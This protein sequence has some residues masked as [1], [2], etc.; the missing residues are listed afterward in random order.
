M[1]ISKSRVGSWIPLVPVLILIWVLAY[2]SVHYIYSNGLNSPPIRSDGFGYYAYLTSIFIDHN[3]QFSSA[4]SHLPFGKP[5]DYGLA[6][7]PGTSRM[8]DRY[9]SGVALLELPFF[10]VAHLYAEK[11]GAVANGYSGIYQFAI[12]VSA[13]FYLTVGAAILYDLLRRR[14]SIPAALITVVLVVFA[15]NV[16]HYA[17]YDAS[18]SHIYSFSLAAAILWLAARYRDNGRH[19]TKTLALMGF[20]CG[21]SMLVRA[22]NIILIILPFS[23]IL[24][25]EIRQRNAFGAICR[26][27]VVGAVAFAVWLPQLLIWH[28]ASGQWLAD[29]YHVVLPEAH[30]NWSDP[31]LLPFLI[32][33]RKGALFWTPL[34]ALAFL[35]YWR[36]V[37]REGL[38]AVGVGL[39]I[40]L[41]IYICA[42]W[43][44]WPFGGSFGSRPMVDIMPMIALPLAAVV[45]GL[46]RRRR[47]VLTSV[48]AVVLIA[49]NLTLMFSYWHHFVPY[50]EANVQ[51]F[52]TLPAKLGTLFQPYP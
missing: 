33:M 12:G 38:F 14:Y 13:I 16:F 27:G 30:F 19:R 31:Q 1:R 37:A 32:S 21:L 23:V 44:S 22:T 26:G 46:A 8:F 28:H 4:V 52:V 7:M 49:V 43:Y 25:H 2:L 20:V 50:D 24:E 6:Q 29:P 40:L 3:L 11:S 9:S 39:V 42:S 41:Q 5:I 47:Y 18:F 48:V 34:I 10:T 17:T 15:T 35:G 45:D 51:T 36:L